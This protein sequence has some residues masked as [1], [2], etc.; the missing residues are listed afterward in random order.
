MKILNGIAYNLNWILIQLNS[1]FEINRI[2]LNSNLNEIQNSNTMK[3]KFHSM[4]LNSIQFNQN[5]IE[6]NF[7]SSSMQCHAIP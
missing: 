4:Y 6:L 7:D 3:F 1:K 5:S 2:K